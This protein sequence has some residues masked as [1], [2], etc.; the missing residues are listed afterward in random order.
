[1]CFGDWKR[2]QNLTL[3]ITLGSISL[4]W[5]L[6]T[7]AISFTKRNVKKKKK[8]VFAKTEERFHERKSRD[9]MTQ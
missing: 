3:P 2:F 4:G 8:K 9:F 7:E 6:N 5:F 1:M